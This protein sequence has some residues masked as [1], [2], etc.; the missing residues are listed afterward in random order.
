ME[1]QQLAPRPYIRPYKKEGIALH[2]EETV[3]TLLDNTQD[4]SSILAHSDQI[5]D[6]HF[7]SGRTGEYKK[8]AWKLNITATTLGH[9]V[10]RNAM[11]DMLETHHY[12]RT[13]APPSLDIDTYI[14]RGGHSEAMAAAS[15]SAYW[16]K[17]HTIRT[18]EEISSY[19]SHR[20]P[21]YANYSAND[22]L[23]IGSLRDWRMGP[24]KNR[25]PIDDRAINPTQRML[26]TFQGNIGTAT[27]LLCAKAI[28]HLIHKNSNA[29]SQE[30]YSAAMES[31]NLISWQTTGNRHYGW[32]PDWKERQENNDRPKGM[33]PHDGVQALLTIPPSKLTLPNQFASSK[34]GSTVMQDPNFCQHAALRDGPVIRA[35]LCAGNIFVTQNDRGVREV[36][37]S[38]FNTFGMDPRNGERYSLGGIALAIGGVALKN[39]ILP[40]YEARKKA[41]MAGH[42]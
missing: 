33:S 16:L 7:N 15:N 13:T 35:G 22:T 9:L 19:C 14:D 6:K 39:I 3:Q 12:F 25:W 40:A 2:A 26:D 21:L 42:L 11:L 8:T 10:V 27:S 36:A 1:K 34:D 29:D 18:F 4:T 31:V 24:G 32:V 38:F 37:E 28:H 20:Y 41:E 30:L 23:Y 17:V 5:I